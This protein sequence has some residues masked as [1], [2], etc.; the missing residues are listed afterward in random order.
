MVKISA[1]A[2]L[3]KKDEIQADLNQV[4]DIRFLDV[5]TLVVKVTRRCNLNCE[6]CYENITNDGDMDIQVFKDLASKAFLNSK[7]DTIEFLFHG[8]E[9]TILADEFF[10]EAFSFCQSLAEKTQKKLKLSMQSNLFNLTQS[11]IELFKKYD[12]SI[13]VSLDGSSDLTDAMRPG[14]RRATDNFVKAREQGLQVGI[15]MTINQSNFDKFGQIL[16]W[17]SSSISVRTVKANVVYSV[18]TGRDLPSMLPEQ[19]F[20]AQKTILDYMLE[21]GTEG[22]LE[23]NLIWQMGWFLRENDH[24]TTS[25]CHAKR[26]GAGSRVLGITTDGKILPCGRFQWDDSEYYLSDLSQV[27]QEESYKSKV[28]AFH[29]RVPENWFDCDDCAARKICN[30]GCQAFIARS[31]SRANVEC[32]PTKMLYNYFLER[33]SDLVKLFDSLSDEDHFLVSSYSDGPYGD[34]TKEPY[35]DIYYDKYNDN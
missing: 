6:Y 34:G 3:V 26:C 28:E 29:D 4:Y 25:L 23:H 1:S 18:G 33:Q 21:H 24:E 32:L 16:D 7:R 14:S 30:F 15:L 5:S 11:K 9:P 13:G 17:L 22:V 35:R 10:V 8:G 2:V 20:L 12:V 19:I 31:K 27:E